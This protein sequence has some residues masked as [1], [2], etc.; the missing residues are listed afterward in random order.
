MCSLVSGLVIVVRVD[1]L[2]FCFFTIATFMVTPA[3]YFDGLHRILYRA[4]EEVDL[5]DSM[6]TVLSP[7]QSSK[8]YYYSYASILNHGS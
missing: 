6:K 7:L 4:I 1:S 5:Q 8:D 2:G 3:C